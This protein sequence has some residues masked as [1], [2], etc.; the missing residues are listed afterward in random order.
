M[1]H[2]DDDTLH[3][4][5]VH[6]YTAVNRISAGNQQFILSPRP[7]EALTE[8][9]SGIKVQQL[10]VR[11]RSLRGADSKHRFTT[12]S[13]LEAAFLPESEAVSTVPYG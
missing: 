4:P 9:V 3:T 5:D 8:T 13:L 6:V 1:V 7:G 11:P 2:T 12:S 10:S